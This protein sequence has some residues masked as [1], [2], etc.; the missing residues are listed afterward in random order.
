MLN[1]DAP[2]TECGFVLNVDTDMAKLVG[3]EFTGAV[4]DPCQGRSRKGSL[5]DSGVQMAKAS[6][7]LFALL[8]PNTGE[9]Y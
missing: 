4:G 7:R 8:T 5:F 3:G 6:R 2:M 1:T 9:R